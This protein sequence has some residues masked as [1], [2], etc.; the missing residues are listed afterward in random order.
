[1]EKFEEDWCQ[2]FKYLVEFTSEAIWFGL[3]WEVFGYWLNLHTSYSSIHDLIFRA[4]MFMGTYPFLLGYAI[5]W[6]VL[7]QSSLTILFFPVVLVVMSAL[8][9]WF[10][11]FFVFFPN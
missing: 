5:C 11:L 4:H 1:L 8:S 6:F 9:F 2:F 7:V 3:S 10:Y